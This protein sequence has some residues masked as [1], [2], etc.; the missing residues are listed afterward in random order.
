MDRII[1]RKMREVDI[2]A[3]MKIELN[4][5]ST[6]WS[7]YSFLVEIYKKNAVSKVAVFEERPVGYICA[8]YLFHESHI[9]N[10]AVDQALRRQGVATLLMNETLRELKGKEAVFIY[11]E[12][13]ASNAGARKFYELFGFSVE[14]VRKKYY[15]NPV[16][17]ALIMMGR[18]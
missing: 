6:P 14:S 11:L 18:L 3:I 1:T 15:I 4:S 12:V 7:E 17:D 13:R 16:E 5:F 10:L 9:L 8:N 2:P